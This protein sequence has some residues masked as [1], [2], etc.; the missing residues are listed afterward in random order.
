MPLFWDKPVMAS[1]IVDLVLLHPPKKGLDL[2][3]EDKHIAT[4]PVV[5]LENAFNGYSTSG[6]S[7][8][9]VHMAQHPFHG[10]STSGTS[11]RLVHMA[12]HS[13]FQSIAAPLG[14]FNSV[15]ILSCL[16]C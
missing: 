12:Q 9:L 14:L 11:P 1:V 8:R 13:F 6:T 10:Y 16:R 4:V 7:P 5:R 2:P 15:Q 3:E